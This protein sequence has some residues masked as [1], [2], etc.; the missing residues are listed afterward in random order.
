MSWVLIPEGGSPF[1][2]RPLPLY[3]DRGSETDRD[4]REEYGQLGKEDGIRI[5]KPSLS[6]G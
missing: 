3:S 1:F 6:G 2:F 5:P 4:N